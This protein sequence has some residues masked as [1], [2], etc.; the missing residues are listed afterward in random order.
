MV[1]FCTVCDK[2]R[3]IAKLNYCTSVPLSSTLPTYGAVTIT[4]AAKIT[5]RKYSPRT[6]WQIKATSM[7]VAVIFM[8]TILYL[9]L[10]VF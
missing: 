2:C 1:L 6:Q 8:T 7:C 3:P 4:V 5:A 10:E 9:Y